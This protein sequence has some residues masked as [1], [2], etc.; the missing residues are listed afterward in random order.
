MLTYFLHLQFLKLEYNHYAH[1]NNNY[2][3]YFRL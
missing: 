1:G 3:V 2:Y